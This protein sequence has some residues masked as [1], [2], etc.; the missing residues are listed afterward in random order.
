MDKTGPV[1]EVN[2][3]RLL[4]ENKMFDGL[5]IE[6]SKVNINIGRKL[7]FFNGK[8]RARQMRGCTEGSQEIINQGKVK[9]FLEGD[10]S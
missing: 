1:L 8:I 10:A 7:A 2:F 6:R 4:N 9:H 5:L 3:F